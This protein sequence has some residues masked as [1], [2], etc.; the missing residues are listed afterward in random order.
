VVIFK[1]YNPE[2]F[3]KA[4]E[5]FNLKSKKATELNCIISTLPDLLEET[6]EITRKLDKFI[7]IDYFTFYDKQV[8]EKMTQFT[9]LRPLIEEVRT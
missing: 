9:E 7:K 5:I 1:E 8:L 6:I 2:L 3:N 4:K